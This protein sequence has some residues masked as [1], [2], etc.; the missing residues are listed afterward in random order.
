MI[1]TF[2]TQRCMLV[3]VCEEDRYDVFALYKNEVV[4]KY[5]G[6]TIGR[7]TFDN[8]FDRLL[9]DGAPPNWIIRLK[10]SK[11][12]VGVI[13]ISSHHDGK[14]MELSYQLLPEFWGKG[15]AR[16]C[17]LA[18][19]S[20]ARKELHLSSIIAET[21]AANT[22]S[23]G[24]LEQ[25]GFRAEKT[26]VRFDEKQFIYRKPLTELLLIF[27]GLPAS[28]KTSLA[29]TLAQELNLEFIDKDDFLEAMFETE[30]CGSIGERRHLSRLSD[31]TFK[32]AVIAAPRAA[33][34][35]FWRGP[36][37][38]E[39]SGTSVDWVFELPVEIVEIYCKCPA[40]IAALRFTSRKRHPSHFDN[41]RT[42]EDLRKS[43]DILLRD[44]PLGLGKLIRV[45]TASQ[46][47]IA[48]VV[49]SIRSIASNLS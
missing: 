23:R 33:V 34:V 28:G 15:L 27:T 7:T 6:G 45:N 26:L 31:Q 38:A 10:A 11:V 8:M 12:F 49:N 21:Q 1:K 35:S 44:G 37:V 47:D 17:L 43:F 30:G 46:V 20:Y 29:R 19:L 24:L 4:R 39:S 36:S 3:P 14:D 48:Q 18:L 16:E 25:T 41:T 2:E 42:L 9:I 40:E 13:S 5:L 32:K 22:A